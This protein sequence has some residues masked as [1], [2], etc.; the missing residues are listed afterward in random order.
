M[1]SNNS[2]LI[3]PTWKTLELN[4]QKRFNLHRK[5]LSVNTAIGLS[6]EQAPFCS[7]P[8]LVFTGHTSDILDVSWSKVFLF[9]LVKRITSKV[10]EKL[11]LESFHSFRL[12]GQNLSTLAYL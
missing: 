1:Y 2:L 6:E 11:F 12:I 3:L 7:K 10:Y 9:F 5:S 4:I 8:L